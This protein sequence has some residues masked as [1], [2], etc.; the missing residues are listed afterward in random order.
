MH[1]IFWGQFVLVGLLIGACG[2]PTP[3][4][5]ERED[6]GRPE[7]VAT[8]EVSTGDAIP[9]VDNVLLIT[10]DTLRWDALGFS[11][12][13]RSRTPHLDRLQAY[14]QRNSR[15]PSSTPSTLYHRPAVG[16]RWWVASDGWRVESGEWR[17]VE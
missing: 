9:S 15:P 1:P 7:P 2:S 3:E 6:A 11:G 16:G 14:S 13:S 5:P 10:I 12:S 4:S 17:A 8:A